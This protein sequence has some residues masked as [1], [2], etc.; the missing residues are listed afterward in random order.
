VQA[1]VRAARILI[2]LGLRGYFIVRPRGC[3]RVHPILADGRRRRG[4]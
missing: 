2:R 4:G 3:L 1:K